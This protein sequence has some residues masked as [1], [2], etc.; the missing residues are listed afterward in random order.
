MQENYFIS[1]K[2][3]FHLQSGN[4]FNFLIGDSITKIRVNF[5]ILEK[6]MRSSTSAW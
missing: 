3:L 6:E 2:V 1:N 5:F 4:N